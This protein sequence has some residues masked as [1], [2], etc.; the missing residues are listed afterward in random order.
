[1]KRT[2]LIHHLINQTEEGDFIKKAIRGNTLWTLWRKNGE[3]HIVCYQL[4]NK[5]DSIWDYE[6]EY[7]KTPPSSFSC[8]MTYLDKTS[9]LCKK[10]RKE[11]IEYWN[12]SRTKKE[13]IKNLFKISKLQKKRLKITI[14]AKEGHA[15]LLHNISVVEADLIVEAVSTG[16]EGR[17]LT[18]NRLYSVPLRLVTDNMSLIDLE[19]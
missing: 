12:R 8:P 16:V 2:K 10:W 1:M 18:N 19:N 14:L 7:E 5:G 6:T 9:V 11:T 13:R 15:L 3:L 4:K 17:F